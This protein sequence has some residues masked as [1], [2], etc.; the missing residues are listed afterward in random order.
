MISRFLNTSNRI[1]VALSRAKHGLYCIGNLDMLAEANFEWSEVLRTAQRNNLLG[2]E[3]V[4]TCGQHPQND[5][6]VQRPLDFERRP[7]GGCQLMCGS[8]LRCGHM[9]QLHC[10]AVD[11]DHVKYK[12]TKP[13]SK[14]IPW[15]GHYCQQQCSHPGE[16][17]ECTFLVKKTVRLCGHEIDFR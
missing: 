15:C 12:C 5:I 7:D 13:C 8:R 4:L 10:H 14:I 17:S 16:C 2:S 9:C 1:C 3:L 6:Y 11:R